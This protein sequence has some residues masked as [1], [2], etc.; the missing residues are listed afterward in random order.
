MVHLR[1]R[2]WGLLKSTGSGLKKSKGL[3]LKKRNCLWLKESKGFGLRSYCDVLAAA[4]HKVRPAD[5]MVLVWGVGSEVRGLG[6]G[7]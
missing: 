4:A 7:I 5:Q 6:F 3:G 1:V 2:I